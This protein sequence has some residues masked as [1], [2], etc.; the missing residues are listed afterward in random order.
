MSNGEDTG[1][2]RALIWVDE[3]ESDFEYVMSVPEEK[4]I[5]PGWLKSYGDDLY[6]VPATL[7]EKYEESVRLRR[8]A[9]EELTVI[10]RA[11]KGK[12]RPLFLGVHPQGAVVVDVTAEDTHDF[13]Q[14]FPGGVSGS[15]E[16]AVDGGVADRGSCSLLD[17]P[18][19]H[20]G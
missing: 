13:L 20:P 14:D 9:D 3:Y 18:G 16:G 4:H 12:Y 7:V 19:E 17:F 10:V 8:E 15:G 11:G 5:T 1:M 2:V 6:E